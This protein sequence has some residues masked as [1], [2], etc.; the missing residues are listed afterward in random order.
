MLYLHSE[1]PC[2]LRTLWGW[3]FTPVM[4][5]LETAAAGN[6][7]PSP[8]R[9]NI[10]TVLTHKT[11]RKTMGRGAQCHSEPHPTLTNSLRASSGTGLSSP[12]GLLLFA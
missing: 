5:L 9:R 6:L 3:G 8:A 10:F 7:L 2:S 1:L 11:V 4:E 12:R